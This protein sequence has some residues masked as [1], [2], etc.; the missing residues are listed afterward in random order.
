MNAA[1]VLQA[2]FSMK[3]LLEVF[4]RYDY[5]GKGYLDFYDLKIAWTFLFG[6]KPSSREL[7]RLVR[8]DNIY[9]ENVHFD[10]R[11]DSSTFQKLVMER[12]SDLAPHHETRQ[13]FYAFDTKCQ[14]F[15]TLEDFKRAFNTISPK[16]PKSTVVSSFHQICTSADGKISYREFESLMLKHVHM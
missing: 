1:T 9:N 4:Y 8:P 12:L 2:P 15:L 5:N 16:I 7:H 11:L 13:L 10:I 14:G 3:E 6:Y